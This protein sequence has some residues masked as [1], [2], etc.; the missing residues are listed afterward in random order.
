MKGRILGDVRHFNSMETRAV[1]KFF[2]LQDKTLK[3]IHAILIETIRENAS[4]YASVKNWVAQFNVV[5]FL[6]VMRLV[7]DDPKQ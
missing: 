2:F 3:E 4:S 6:P 7:V 5:I 1:I